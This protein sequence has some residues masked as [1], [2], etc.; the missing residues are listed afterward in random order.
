MDRK[1]GFWWS[2]DSKHLAFT[3][4]DSSEIPLYRIMHQGKDSV[5]LDAQ[6]DH[7]YPFA[8]AANVKVRLGVVLSNGGGVT[9]MDLLCGEPN[10][11]HGD[12]EYLARVNWMNNN[13]LAVQVLNRTHTKLK[14][15]K[16]DIA[17]GKREVLLEEKHDIWITLHDSFTPLDRGL[18]SKHPGGFIWASEKT[19]FRHLYIHDKDGACL[20]P[21][22][23]GDW[24]VEQIAGVNESSGLI[25]F[26]ATLDGPL[27]TNLYQCN[28]FLDWST[29]LESPKRLT[30]GAGRHSVILDHQLLRFIDVYDSLKSPPVVLLCSLLD[31]SVIMSLY[32]QP[33]TV[34]PLKKFQQL[35]PEIVQFTAKDGTALYGTFYL[36]DEKKH[37]PPPYKTLINVYGGPSVQLVSDTWMSTV[38]MRAQYLRSKG[39]LVWKVSCL[40]LSF[41]LCIRTN[42]MDEP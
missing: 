14:L 39:I 31:G 7:A 36:P 42:Y 38:D 28:L 16:F 10:G 1:M 33:P 4:V 32:E 23:Q 2:P 18:N 8:G 40:L 25:Y 12:E 5:G 37:G 19:G 17:T 21:I 20:G 6:E 11:A 24:M 13:T 22:T 15:L 9:W 35:S 41:W 26:T 29:A 27:E 30:R 3:E 34:P